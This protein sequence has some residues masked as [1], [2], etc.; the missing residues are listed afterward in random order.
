MLEQHTPDPRFGFTNERGGAHLARSMMFQELSDILLHFPDPL[1]SREEIVSAVIEENILGK[2]SVQT[3]KLTVRHLSTLYGLDYQTTLFRALRYFWSRDQESNKMLACLC[4][5][6][7][8]SVFRQSAN[9]ILSIP[10]G[11]RFSRQDLEEAI[12]NDE[13]GRFSKS[14]LKSTAQNIAS[15]WTQS[16]HLTGCVKKIRS[17]ATQTPGSVAYAL[18]L[19][20]LSG[21]RGLELFR[22]E[23]AKLLDCTPEKAIELAEVASR[24]GWIVFKRVGNIIEV[25]FPNLINQEEMEWLREQS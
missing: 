18:L 12:E 8:D 7:R 4:A 17:Q 2:R 16:G 19:G 22:T 9:F 1:T 21:A 13:S 5:Y 14:T 10:G 20:Y 23:Y 24:K 3:R 25:L 15:S 11:V 6:T